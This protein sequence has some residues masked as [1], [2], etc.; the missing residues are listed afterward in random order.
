MRIPK[1]GVVGSW[2]AGRTD[3]LRPE[4]SAW[5]KEAGARGVTGGARARRLHGVKVVIFVRAAH[6]FIAGL[7]LLGG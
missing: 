2:I 4:G 6:L 5:R 7:L 3:S 1:R